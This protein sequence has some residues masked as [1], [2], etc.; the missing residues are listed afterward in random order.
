[1]A[2]FNFDQNE[3]YNNTRASTLNLNTNLRNSAKKETKDV[4][5]K[6]LKEDLYNSLSQA[7]IK[8]YFTPYFPLKIV[9]LT[10]ILVSTVLTSYLVIKS[11]LVYF[12]FQVAESSRIIYETPALFPK[13]KF[14]N[15]NG[16]NKSKI[17][18]FNYNERKMLDHD[19]SDIL[20]ECWFNGNKCTPSDFSW[21]YDYF[22]DTC[23]TFN[24]D[25][26]NKSDLKKS[27]IAGF[28]FGLQ[29]TLYVNSNETK[30]DE[31]YE[32]GAVIRIDNSSYLSD[33]SNSGIFVSP[34][35]CTY[36]SVEREFRTMLPKPYSNCEVDTNSPLFV[37]NLE[38]YNLIGQS[39]YEY[40]QQLCLA[41]CLQKEFHK[42]HNCSY[43]YL[44]SLYDNVTHCN[45]NVSERIDSSADSFDQNFI[46]NECLPVCPLE[47]N[48]TLYKT[49]YSFSQLNAN[50]YI[51]YILNNPNLVKDFKNRTIDAEV[52]RESIVS[53]IVFY[54]SLSYTLTTEIPQVDIVSLLGSIGGNLSLFLGVSFFSLCEI[55]EVAIEMFYALKNRE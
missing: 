32:F 38:F 16:Y 20:I 27:T 50:K 36:I 11:I 33:D 41:Q 13:V 18:I 31:S 47:C 49:T 9:L 15:L 17:K 46:Y 51:D 4:I 55:F 34:G 52:A 3:K 6:L 48:Q 53:V 8:T 1:M 26:D 22:Y 2:T 39:E 29:L 7:I 12:S 30:R 21:S 35:F 25:I 24:L 14:C 23:Y 40:T 19:L 5:K 44:L 10:F 28:N 43:L 54:E 37:S 45:S 42:K